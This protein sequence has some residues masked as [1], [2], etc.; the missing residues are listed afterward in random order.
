MHSSPVS[1]D[2]RKN[3]RLGRQSLVRKRAEKRKA[4]AGWRLAAGRL[5]STNRET[6]ATPNVA[7]G[8]AAD[9]RSV[10]YQLRASDRVPVAWFHRPVGCQLLLPDGPALAV[11]IERHIA[12]R[13]WFPVCHP[14]IGRGWGDRQH[15]ALGHRRYDS[16]V[17]WLPQSTWDFSRLRESVAAYNVLNEIH[18]KYYQF[19][20]NMLVALVFVYI[21]RRQHLGFARAPFGGLDLGFV[22]LVVILFVGSRD[23]LRQVFQSDIESSMPETG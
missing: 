16:P 6:E 2:D 14:R 3:P 20:G 22:L 5:V 19:H 18:Y 21:A 1:H 15:G 12:D 9:E 23:T 4:P 11:G 17:D 13:R 8:A 7:I 10:V